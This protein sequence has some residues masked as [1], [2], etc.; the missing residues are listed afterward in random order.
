VKEGAGDCVVKRWASDVE[1]FVSLSR[2]ETERLEAGIHRY[3][4]DHRL[5]PYS[6]EENSKTVWSDCS[7]HI[8][9]AHVEW[10]AQS[11]ASFKFPPRSRTLDRSSELQTMEQS[12]VNVLAWLESAFVEFTL[13]HEMEAF[14][15]WRDLVLLC[16]GC[17][18]EL[19]ARPD[20]FTDFVEIL[21]WQVQEAG[22]ELLWNDGE[23]GGNIFVHTITEFVEDVRSDDLLPPRL[24][25]KVRALA[26]LV[27]LVELDEDAPA[28]VE[29]IME[30]E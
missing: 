16:C 12:G 13:T 23:G 21:N 9:A 26:Q 11:R 7:R 3:E 14:E 29:M 19:R 4:F 1:E 27:P 6:Q 10:L 18:E 2:D 20:Y 25:K 17:I 24:V 5:G 22:A 15:E 28:V 8:T 30:A